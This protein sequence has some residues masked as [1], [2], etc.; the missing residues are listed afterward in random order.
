MPAVAQHQAMPF[1]HFPTSYPIA[2]HPSTPSMSPATIDGSPSRPRWATDTPILKPRGYTSPEPSP[3]LHQLQQSPHHPSTPLPLLHT[4]QA[5][6]LVSVVQ[7]PPST[8]AT[9]P[10]AYPN[11]IALYD[12]PT[13]ESDPGVTE[14]TGYVSPQEVDPFFN[15]S[16]RGTPPPPSKGGK[17]SSVSAQ[18][19]SSKKNDG[20]QATFLSKLYAIL[21]QPEYHHIIRWD[22][23][24]QV[25]I[26]EKPDELANKILPLVYKQ[27]RFASFSRQLNIY[28][29]MRKVSLRHVERGIS[30]PDASTWSHDTLRRTSTQAEIL[31]FKRRVPPR[32]SQAKKRQLSLAAMRDTEGL[33]SDSDDPYSPPDAYHHHLI[34]T[35]EERRRAWAPQPLPLGSSHEPQIP[36]ASLPQARPAPHPAALAGSSIIHGSAPAGLAPAFV[37]RPAVRERHASPSGLDDFA[38]AYRSSARPIPQSLAVGTPAIF[39]PSLATTSP[40]SAPSPGIHMA[41]TAMAHMRTGSGDNYSTTLYS[42]SSPLAA[43]SWLPGDI[44]SSP[45]E[46]MYR[47]DQPSSWARRGF[48]DFAHNPMPHPTRPP[49]SS[50]SSMSMSPDTATNLAQTPLAAS[51]PLNM[52]ALT[53]LAM[54]LANQ[55][56]SPM[57]GGADDPPATVSPGVYQIG[58]SLPSQRP[59]VPIGSP[60]TKASASKRS[61]RRATVTSPYATMPVRRPLVYQSLSEHDVNCS[62]RGEH[63][64]VTSEGGAIFAGTISHKS[65]EGLKTQGGWTREDSPEELEDERRSFWQDKDR[66]HDRQP[67]PDLPS[68]DIRGLGRHPFEGIGVLEEVG[69]QH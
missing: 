43:A 42:P 68:A 50:S 18:T 5:T 37:L 60:A 3:P 40:A 10:R 13:G 11:R 61:E 53:P 21:E 26:I 15:P 33:S 31:N 39:H 27:S 29:W 49:T 58:F 30:D 20:K 1:A 22:E 62:R 67:S 56:M 34:R 51:L 69:V 2:Y 65:A 54:P 17:R 36:V 6:P 55:A 47:V 64:R 48:T 59:A 52:A 28:G 9:Q 8:P 35:H 66:G 7:P 44:E 45:H 57:A 63:N 16:I 4:Y 12:S 38:S 24:G 41:Q 23:A 19:Q 46:E 32:P 25:I 14:G